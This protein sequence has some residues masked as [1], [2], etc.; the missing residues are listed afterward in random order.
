MRKLIFSL[1]MCAVMAT[2]VLASPTIETTRL[3]D[4]LNGLTVAPTAGSSSVTVTTDMVP[5]SLDS[6]WKI[7]D[8]GMSP[9]TLVFKVTDASYSD[10]GT[11]GV[12]DAGNPSQTVQL[13]DGT[14]VQPGDQATLSI[15]AD[16]SVWAGFVNYSGAGT[17]VAHHDT[18]LDFPGKVFGYYFDTEDMGAGNGGFWHSDTGLNADSGDHMAAYLGQ[19][20]TLNI[21][22]LGNLDWD[23]GYLLAWEVGDLRSAD[24]DYDDLVIMVESV[25][26]IPAPGAILL[27]SIGV[28]IVGWMRRRRSL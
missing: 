18:G 26:P 10:L 4:L 25:K 13:W 14:D 28:S 11:F 9:A 20:D 8:S 3:Q 7:V 21:P 24:K 23:N 6:Y 22:V 2:P 1:L 19:G 5:D 27:G 12:Y 15:L 17:S 16:G